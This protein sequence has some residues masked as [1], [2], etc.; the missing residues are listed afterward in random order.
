[1]EGVVLRD[2]ADQPAVALPVGTRV[3]VRSR[4]R[5]AWSGGFEIVTSTAEGYW[6]RRESDWY[7]LPRPFVARD[8]RR[9]S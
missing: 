5:A 3:E 4:Y 1:M 8:V 7:L 6:L 9:R 2:P